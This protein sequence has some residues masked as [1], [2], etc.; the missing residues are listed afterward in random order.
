LALSATSINEN[1]AA[2]SAVGTFSTTDADTGNTFTYSLVTGTGDTDN[3]AFTVVGNSLQINASPDFEAKPTYN[4]RV[5]TTDQGGL[6]FEKAFTININDLPEPKVLKPNANNVF[7]I[8]GAAQQL[9]LT[10][11]KNNSTLVNEI[12]VYVVDDDQARIGTL[13]PGANGYTQAALARG[14]VIF[15]SLTNPPQGFNSQL[16]RILGEFTPNTRLG[17]YAVQNG[18]TDAVLKGQNQTVFFSNALNVSSLGNNAFS[19]LWRTPDGS[20]SLNLE[21][22]LE[23][24]TETKPLGTATQSQPEGEMLDLRG[25]TTNSVNATFTVN[26]EAAYNNFVGFYRVMDETGAINTTN[27]II[28]PGEAGYAQAAVRDAQSLGINLNVGNQSTASFNSSLGKSLFAP[29]IISNG[30]TEQV[31]SGQKVNDI[32]FSFLGANSDKVDHIRMLGD[33]TFGFEDITGGGDLDYNDMVMRVS[34]S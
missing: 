16:S 23:S 24:T 34:F 20:N 7:S 13:S 25:L 18:T 2:N 12:G 17:L 22:K 19:L 27:G 31:L 14:Q 4:I 9:K 6:P 3:T 21:T 28:R 26:R 10:L 5:R 8:E 1:V 11:T 15:S 29:F 33:N 30:T 32:Y